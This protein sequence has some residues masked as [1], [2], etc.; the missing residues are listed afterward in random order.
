MCETSGSELQSVSVELWKY[1]WVLEPHTL[2]PTF[3]EEHLTITRRE[4]RLQLT[5]LLECE[6]CACHLQQLGRM[7]EGSIP[8]F[9]KRL[10]HH[11]YVESRTSDLLTHVSLG[12]R[13][14]TLPSPSLGLEYRDNDNDFC[15]DCNMFKF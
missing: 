1:V 4:G 6:R 3:V 12:A 5:A 11:L 7:S 2:I 9:L 8:E 14:R 10:W 15:D 13:V